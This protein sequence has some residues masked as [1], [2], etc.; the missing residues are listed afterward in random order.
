MGL[1]E[2]GI[3]LATV[4]VALVTA[5]ATVINY[6]FFRSQIDPDVIVYSETDERRPS[7][8]IL[9]IENVGKG[10]ALNVS[11]SSDRPI[12]EKAYGIKIEDAKSPSEMESGPLINGIPSLALGRRGSSLGVNMAA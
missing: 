7:L 5:T 1:S 8:V 2:F 10:L 6:F 3:L 11:F 9:V 12:P 4:A